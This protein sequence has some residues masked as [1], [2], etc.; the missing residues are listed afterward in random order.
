MSENKLFQVPDKNINDV[1][2]NIN[3][4]FSIDHFVKVSILEKSTGALYEGGESINSGIPIH[5]FHIIFDTKPNITKK[6]NILII[7]FQFFGDIKT[8]LVITNE[9]KMEIRKL[10]FQMEISNKLIQQLIEQ[11]KNSLEENK[12]IKNE[13]KELKIAKGIIPQ[14]YISLKNDVEELKNV[15]EE[16]KKRINELLNEISLTKRIAQE[17]ENSEIIK[18]LRQYAKFSIIQDSESRT[19]PYVYQAFEFPSL[20]CNGDF[21]AKYSGI[22][23]RD[24]KVVLE[25]N[26]MTQIIEKQKKLE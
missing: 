9:D 24:G 17:L 2:Y 20:I 19:I 3:L 6:D 22:V 25:K 12:T 10:G 7:N 13:I 16:S 4:N 18:A 14:Y 26:C 8:T 11:M 5:H 15:V 1:D 21:Y 23:E